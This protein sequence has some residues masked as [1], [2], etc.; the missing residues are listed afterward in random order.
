M[1]RGLEMRRLAHAWIVLALLLASAAAAA[2]EEY[3]DAMVSDLG[4]SKAPGCELCHRSGEAS[5]GPTDTPF[6]RSAIDRGLVAKDVGSLAD[7]LDRMQK[8]G[9][10]SDGD[11]AEDLDELSWGG[12]PNHADLPE[13][14]RIDTVSYGCSRSGETARGNGSIALALAGAI[15][16]RRRRGGARGR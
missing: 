7:A 13:A 15:F 9:V 12:D 11:G 14:G 8:D 2:S 1:S 10:D 4:L 16:A 6:A 5:L 3:P